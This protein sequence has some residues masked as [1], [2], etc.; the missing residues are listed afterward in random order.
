MRGVTAPLKPADWVFIWLASHLASFLDSYGG[1]KKTLKDNLLTFQRQDC[2]RPCPVQP[3]EGMAHLR[4]MQNQVQKRSFHQLSPPSFLSK[5][6]RNPVAVWLSTNNQG[7]GLG[8]DRKC[9]NA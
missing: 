1:R 7:G 6:G 8:R 4:D 3:A 5:T 9:C 2:G